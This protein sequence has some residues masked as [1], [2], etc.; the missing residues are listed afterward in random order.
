MWRLPVLY[1]ALTQVGWEQYFSSTGKPLRWYEDEVVLTLDEDGTTDVEGDAEFDVVMV[2][3]GTWNEVACNQPIL[4]DGGFVADEV[5]G[6]S[7]EYNLIIWED[8][9][10]WTHIDRPKAIALTTLYFNDVSGA[11]Q[12]IDMEFAD[13]KFHFTVTDDPSAAQTDIE[14][15]VT[16]ELGH[17][18]GLDHS[19]LAQA[20]MYFSSGSGDFQKRDLH[21]DDIAGLCAIYE[22]PSYPDGLDGSSESG[23]TP[24]EDSD[25]G[26]CA[27]SG[28]KS[29]QGPGTVLVSAFLLV[30]GLFFRR[31]W[32]STSLVMLGVMT[33]YASPAF[34]GQDFDIQVRSRVLQ[35]RRLPAIVVT[36]R[37]DMRGFEVILKQG[38]TVVGR[39][40]PLN[41]RAGRTREFE[42]RQAPGVMEYR[43]EI[44]H[45][46]IQRPELLTFEVVVA[47]PMEIRISRETV[48]LSDGSI[49]FSASEPVSRVALVVLGEQ[50]RTLVDED[51]DVE[52]R[53][54]A[55]TSV[56]FEP[57]IGTVT[58]VRLT[59]YDRWGFYNGIE[60]T[61]F[62][63]EI[64]HEEVNFEFGKASISASEGPKL[65]RTLQE[66]HKALRKLRSEFKARLYIAGYTD[67][68]G[69]RGYNQDLSN[70]RARSISK[71]FRSH[72]LSVGVCY[73]GFGEDAPAVQTPD[74]TREPRNRRTVH[75]LA[76]QHPPVSKTF[77]RSNWK[78]L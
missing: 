35:G 54:G 31:G 21:Q 36:A 37:A 48:D 27:V 38:E 75:V 28:G 9:S 24:P 63:I 22:T 29:G 8:E 59:A 32:R 4:V 20:T 7:T 45:A 39:Y 10:E 70:R 19:F 74:E 40:G 69:T 60:I 72:G 50:G 77:P 25:G 78:C 61:P 5:P 43:A 16:H 17:V 6:E 33:L 57:P 64:P 62:F 18:L 1:L 13:H 73:Q 44:S 26:G 14:N 41:L 55:M 34:A 65:S 51:V 66:V 53:A 71:W 11:I 30:C 42:I 15:T 2:S 67:S 52:S 23:W 3:M 58:L 46:G 56:Q 76:N 49:S 68:V 47:R 12:K